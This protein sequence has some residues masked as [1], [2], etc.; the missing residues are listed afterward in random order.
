MLLSR[1]SDLRSD[2]SRVQRNEVSESRAQRCLNRLRSSWM[3][4]KCFR[5][6]ASISRMMNF[7][8]IGSSDS[9][10][11]L[12]VSS[13]RDPPLDVSMSKIDT[14]SKYEVNGDGIQEVFRKHAKRRNEILRELRSI[15]GPMVFIAVPQ[16]CTFEK[17]RIH[18]N[19]YI[20]LQR[21]E[22][23]LRAS[24]PGV[25]VKLSRIVSTRLRNDSASASVEPRASTFRVRYRSEAF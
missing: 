24:S 14:V 18:S 16:L 9:G 3:I 20:D 15:L 17:I 11:T 22:Q 2:E 4:R 1:L 21:S 12:T 10:E 6:I 7:Q 13:F 8:S 23:A 5:L 19:E 25:S